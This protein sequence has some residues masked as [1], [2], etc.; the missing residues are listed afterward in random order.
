LRHVCACMQPTRIDYGDLESC[1]K[2][3]WVLFQDVL[4]VQDRW[5]SSFSLRLAVL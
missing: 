4:V 3:S 5:V 1:D 2:L